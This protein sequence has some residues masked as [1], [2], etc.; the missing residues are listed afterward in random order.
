MFMFS[1]LREDGGMRWKEPFLHMCSNKTWAVFVMA[2][3]WVPPYAVLFEQQYLIC[4][5][6]VFQRDESG[7]LF[8]LLLVFHSTDSPP[9]TCRWKNIRGC[10][11]L[12]WEERMYRPLR[13]LRYTS[14]SLAPFL[15]PS[16]GLNTRDLCV[17]LS[18]LASSCGLSTHP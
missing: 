12:Q 7:I 1:L 14:R 17:S 4:Y 3:A 9:L 8:F 5:W 13:Q 18:P 10:E 2:V 6:I 11:L 16:F 15:G